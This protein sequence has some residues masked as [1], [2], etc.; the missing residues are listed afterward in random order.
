[1]WAAGAFDGGTTHSQLEFTTID[2]EITSN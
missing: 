1:L 2:Y